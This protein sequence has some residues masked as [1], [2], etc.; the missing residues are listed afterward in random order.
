ML[1]GLFD[2][3][4]L[5]RNPIAVDGLDIGALPG[6]FWDK[7]G[8][9]YSPMVQYLTNDTM[10][11]DLHDAFDPL[12]EDSA[13]R[14]GYQLSMEVIQ[15][16]KGVSVD[17]TIAILDEAEDLSLKL[18]KVAGTRIGKGS[19]LVMMGDIKQGE[20][21]YKYD[22]GLAAFVEQSKDEQL[23]GIIYLPEDVRSSVSKV[24]A[25]LK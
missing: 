25:N 2:K 5:W 10:F 12:N 15:N 4:A 17:R 22:N 14:R 24:F 11:D 21:K 23:V 8:H 18:I 13:K 19:M 20:D 1:T 3:M 16:L 9:F 7:V 6:N